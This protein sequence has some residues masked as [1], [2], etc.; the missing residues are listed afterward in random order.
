MNFLLASVAT[1]RLL[2][3]GAFSD[4]VPAEP[5]IHFIM[6]R[7][8]GIE[9]SA[10]PVPIATAARAT[11]PASASKAAANESTAR[12]RHQHVE[13]HRALLLFR[14]DQRDPASTWSGATPLKGYEG[15]LSYIPLDRVRLRFVSDTR[16]GR[17]SLANLGLPHLTNLCPEA[18]GSGL[19]PEFLPPAYPG[20][21]AVIDIDF[22]TLSSCSSSTGRADTDLTLTV[23]K[24][25]TVVATFGRLS[26]QLRLRA[27]DDEPIEA[28]VLNVP[29]RFLAGDRSDKDPHAVDG[30]PHYFAY[31][32]MLAKRPACLN[33]PMKMATEAPCKGAMGD[34]TGLNRPAGG[35]PSSVARVLDQINEFTNFECSNTIFP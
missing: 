14:D 27:T 5:G 30:A 34:L 11:G 17:P 2:G 1:I 16:N 20:A 21:S 31:Y 24:S 13:K 28:M 3:L 12:P 7:Q 8:G 23:Q 9:A 6:P 35:K 19:A 29:E 10:G 32:Q 25:L 26:R 22:G 33:P 4:Q 15:L 18:N